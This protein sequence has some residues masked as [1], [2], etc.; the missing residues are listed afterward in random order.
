MRTSKSV[1]HP[2]REIVYRFNDPIW[3][4]D[5]AIRAVT[6]VWDRFSPSTFAGLYRKIRS[7]TMCSNARLRAIPRGEIC[8]AEQ[9]G[10]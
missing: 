8:R 9:R 6:T 3:V 10:G 4:A 2:L 7:H 5:T 1:R